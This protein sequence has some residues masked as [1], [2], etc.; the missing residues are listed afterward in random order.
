M[1]LIVLQKLYRLCLIDVEFL[2]NKLISESDVALKTGKTGIEAVG[3]FQRT[4]G[5]LVLELSIKNTTQFE[6]I[7]D[8][9]LKLNSNSFGLSPA[10]SLPEITLEPGQ[11]HKYVI[12]INVNENNSNKAPVTPITVDCALK[13]SQGIYVF[14]IPVMLSVLLVKQGAI[15]NVIEAKG[16]MQ[17]PTEENMYHKNFNLSSKLTSPQ[18]IKERL[19]DNNFGFIEEGRTDGGSPC[20]YFY[21]KTTNNLAILLQLI[22]KDGE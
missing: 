5:N 9:A 12:G 20:L 14:Q 10:E 15:T 7:N 17:L 21:A 22:F 2:I 19:F 16:L 1:L 13:T 18:K 4:R 11:Y 3:S 8:F 6:S